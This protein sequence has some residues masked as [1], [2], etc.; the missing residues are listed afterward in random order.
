MSVS[1][2]AKQAFRA[3]F[4]P[5]TKYTDAGLEAAYR[6]WMREHGLLSDELSPEQER[7][8]ETCKRGN[9]GYVVEHRLRADGS[10]IVDVRQ[11]VSKVKGH[12]ADGLKTLALILIDRNGKPTDEGGSL[13]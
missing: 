5:M 7:Y 2:A 6:V 9:P 10:C 13:K 11:H 3:H 1:E 8:I 4:A 12:P